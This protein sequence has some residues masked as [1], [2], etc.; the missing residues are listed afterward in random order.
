MVSILFRREWKIVYFDYQFSKNLSDTAHVSPKR[1]GLCWP[2][3]RVRAAAVLIRRKLEGT[4][5]V[6]RRK[7]APQSW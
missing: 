1:F 5:V 2:P 3:R 4:A 7:E 6:L